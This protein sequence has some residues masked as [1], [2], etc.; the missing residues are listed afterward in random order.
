MASR[1]PPRAPSHGPGLGQTTKPPT[2][3][4]PTQV[5]YAQPAIYNN[6]YAG[7]FFAQHNAVPN[8][9]PNN[10]AQ[11][12]WNSHAY[13]NQH[14]QHAYPPVYYSAPHYTA[15]P[16]PNYQ[17][18]YHQPVHPNNSGP[19]GQ[20]HRP[21]MENPARMNYQHQFNQN[22]HPRPLSNQFKSNS[23]HSQTSNHTGFT[24]ETAAF[25][26]NEGRNF[27]KKRKKVHPRGKGKTQKKQKKDV[28]SVVDP[29]YMETVTAYGNSPEEIQRWIDD[30][31]KRF[32][33]KSGETAKD[34]KPGVENLKSAETEAASI[35]STDNAKLHTNRTPTTRHRKLCHHFVKGK[36]NRGD[37]CRYSHDEQAKSDALIKQRKRTE[38]KAYL[39]ARGRQGGRTSL[40][41]K[42]L[43]SDI[44]KEQFIIL[45][46]LR[47]IVRTNYFQ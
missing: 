39:E 17:A 22:Q 30:R 4:P 47:H 8:R 9:Y 34:D 18:W 13:Q 36:C 11:P 28:D 37:N 19:R 33:R 21:N 45:E 38:T 42:L 15:N 24:E 25:R 31:K 41:R 40:L 16:N 29:K 46:C 3:Y 35:T 44:K 20:Q 27:G 1:G 26:K 7:N 12:Y 32:P 23:H 14:Y 43:M 2:Q 5:A 10:Q 6:A